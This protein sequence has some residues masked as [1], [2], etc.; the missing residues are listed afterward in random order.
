MPAHPARV[1]VGGGKSGEAPPRS[2]LIEPLPC[3]LDHDY[4]PG[5]SDGRGDP[6]D[7]VVQVGHMVQRR[8]RHNR[9]HWV[10]HVMVL[11]LGS[12]VVGPVRGLRIDPDSVVP[13]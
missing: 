1:A 7:N 5:G 9:I 2:F 13:V 3:P 8:A 10:G 12:V 11:E 6:V 4:Y